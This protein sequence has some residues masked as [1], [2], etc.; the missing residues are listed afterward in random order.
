[1]SR[2]LGVQEE[3][4]GNAV[5]DS[6]PGIHQDDGQ[7]VKYLRIYGYLLERVELV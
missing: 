1:M 3:L 5:A 6:T 4:C 7:S 2:L